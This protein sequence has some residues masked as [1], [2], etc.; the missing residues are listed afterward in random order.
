M[1]SYFIN[2]IVNEHAED[3]AVGGVI[4]IDVTTNITIENGEDIIGYQYLHGTN[5]DVGGFHVNGAIW[6]SSSKEACYNLICTWNDIIDPNPTYISDNI[7][8]AAAQLIPYAS[9]KD[10]RLSI[11][12]HTSNRRSQ[13]GRGGKPCQS[14]VDMLY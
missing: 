9:P 2:K 1:I 11:T 3:I 10:Y 5:A 4:F 7:K 13:P 12:W 14:R 6:R 8:S